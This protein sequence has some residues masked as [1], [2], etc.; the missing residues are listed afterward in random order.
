MVAARAKDLYA[1]Q[2]K[3]RQ[4]EGQK[5]GGKASAAGRRGEADIVEKL[6]PSTAGKARDKAG[7]AVG[8]SGKCVDYGSKVLAKG[9]PE[10]AEAVDSGKLPV[11]TAA[12]VADL[13][14]KEQ[15]EVVTAPSPKKAANQ[16]LKEKARAEAEAEAAD[17]DLGKWR[18][19]P[20]RYTALA[21]KIDRVL[22]DK[23][24]LGLSTKTLS[25][26]KDESGPHNLYLPKVVT[27]LRNLAERAKE[28][29]TALKVDLTPER[30]EAPANADGEEE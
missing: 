9:V 18:K 10:L 19:G 17:E 22:S 13:P 21:N 7:E 4:K 14:T 24:Y 11:S 15:Q 30:A 1:K 5:R 28:A 2:A 20:G 26:L 8:I 27:A 6:P 12:K 3:E 29:A 16:K 25:R 23:D